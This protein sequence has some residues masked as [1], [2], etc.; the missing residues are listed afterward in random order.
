MEINRICNSPGSRQTQQ[1]T[2]KTQGGSFQSQL[3]SRMRMQSLQDR[4]TLSSTV[5][6]EEPEQLAATTADRAV[7]VKKPVIRPGDEVTIYT[8][9]STETKLEKLRQMA[10][11]S[12]Y[13]GM[14]YEDIYTTIWNRYN[15]AFGGKLSTITALVGPMSQDWCDINYQFIK[16]ADKYVNIPLRRSLEKQG[17][18]D[19]GVYSK[20]ARQII[21]DIRAAPLGYRGMS[22][23]E[24]EAAIFEK[25]KG[26][27]SYLDFISMQGE[28]FNTGVYWNKLGIE[29]SIQLRSHMREE[30]I[31]HYVPNQM[32][33]AG[34]IDAA[35]RGIPDEYIT[36]QA[37]F[38]T[39]FDFK[40]DVRTFYRGMRDTLQNLIVESS[41]YDIKG[42]ID[43][44]INESEL[45]L[46]KHWGKQPA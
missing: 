8:S 30:A 34:L 41:S 3:E 6:E 35:W 24:K 21:S 32:Y 26:K 20:E 37:K 7:E 18:I 19:N 23:E 36:S 13:S 10:E 39:L 27:D 22:F 43:K 15:T 4:F 29:G 42:M 2:R 17:L 5:P 25:Y 16:E 45:M 31:Y 9:D 44:C 12:D 1:T 14:S 40:F 46:E 33:K 38:E 28:L 11:V